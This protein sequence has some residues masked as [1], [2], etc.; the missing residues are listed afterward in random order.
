MNR[1]YQWLS[2]RTSFFHVNASR[3]GTSRT[4]CTEVTVQRESTTLTAGTSAAFDL[5]PFCGQK[6]A[7]AEAVHERLRL[8]ESS[9]PEKREDG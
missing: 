1:L 5:C 3:Q 2:G 8:H 4:V 9:I 7:P 6:L